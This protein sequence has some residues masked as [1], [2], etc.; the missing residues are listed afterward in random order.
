MKSLILGI[1]LILLVGLGG[2]LYRNVAERTT[3]P[4]PLACQDDAKLCPD[5]TAVGRVGPSCEF[6]TCALP[7]V[8][9]PDAN[10]AF[11]I[12]S[13]YIADEN[14]YGAEPTLTAAF[15]RPSV[16]GNPPHTIVVRRFPIAEGQTADDVILA[17]ARYQPADMQAED[18]ERFETVLVNGKQFRA[19]VIERFEAIVHS[20]YFYVREKDVLTFEIVEHDVTE[21]MNPELVVA[22]L[23]E[24][25]ALLAL[26]ATLQ[27]A[28]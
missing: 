28:P 22:D 11:V 2:F 23:P 13:G 25:K 24:H 7:N 19:T 26:L 18:F 14:A 20:S 16:S 9:I 15:V 5:G 27:A 10:I 21:W 4:T 1:V 6:P 17:Q 8:E 3:T 12:P